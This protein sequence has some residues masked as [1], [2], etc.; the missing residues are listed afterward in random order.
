MLTAQRIAAASK[1]W[2]DDPTTTVVAAGARGGLVDGIPVHSV[3]L[4]GHGRAPGGAARHHRAEPVDPPRHLRPVVVHARRAARGAEGRRARP[5]SRSAS[6]RCSVSESPCVGGWRRGLA[7]RLPEGCAAWRCSRSRVCESSSAASSRS[8]TCRSRSTRARSARSIG[9]NGA[10][11]TTLFNCV[12]RLYQ[13]TSGSHRAR[14]PQPARAA[15]APHRAG[16]DR[17]HVPEPRAVPGAHRRAERAWSARTRAAAR[18]GRG[19][20][21]RWRSS[22]GSALADLADAARGRPALRNAQAGRDRARARGAPAAAA[23]RRARGRA[24]ALRGRR[25]R[26]SR[27]VDP[28]RVR[29]ERAARRAPHGDGDGDLRQ[30][31]RARLRV[32]RSPR[33]RPSEIRDDPRVI[34]AYLGNDGRV[35]LLC[36]RAAHRRLRRGAGA[37]RHRL[38]GR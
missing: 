38:H 19:A 4:R 8:P 28:R 3:R 1:D 25:A 23:A 35:S 36:G 24:H 5:G 22:S 29:A 34:E 14:R 16:R 6:T 30:G 33:A 20:P 13:P 9:P 27:A 18:R 12:S 2:A 17:A 11:K 37:A 21:T 7:S 31:R 26:R 32:A 15:R 10:G